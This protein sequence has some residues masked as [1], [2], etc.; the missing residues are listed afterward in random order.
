MCAAFYNIIAAWAPYLEKREEF[1]E[2]IKFYEVAIEMK[3]LL[4]QGG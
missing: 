1:S 2:I 3:A 4:K